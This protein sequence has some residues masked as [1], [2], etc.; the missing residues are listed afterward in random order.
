M[1]S[2]LMCSSGLVPRGAEPALSIRASVRLTGRER[3]GAAK[4]HAG[5]DAGPRRVRCTRMRA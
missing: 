5:Q 1:M 4:S 2:L 3:L